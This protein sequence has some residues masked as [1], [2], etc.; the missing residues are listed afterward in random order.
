MPDS[1][2]H[3]R[4]RTRR[5]SRGQVQEVTGAILILARLVQQLFAPIPLHLLAVALG[6][7]GVL[8]L[9]LGASWS[10]PPPSG[11]PDA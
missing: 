1:G 2:Q 10:Q 4:I 5:R 7:L 8:L 6:F 11:P 9:V 3:H